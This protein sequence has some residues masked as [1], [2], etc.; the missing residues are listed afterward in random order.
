[1]H[2]EIDFE[3]F[4]TL[5]GRRKSEE[6]DYNDV[7]RRLLKLP[8]KLNSEGKSGD[9]EWVSKGFRFPEG[10]EFKAEFRG[11]EYFAAIRGGKFVYDG[12]AYNSF[13]GAAKVITGGQ[14]NGW[15]FWLQ[16]QPGGRWRK[17]Y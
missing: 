11:I 12:I 1:M 13:S 5:T 3:V 4:Q 17:V 14:R 8:P 16:K 2:V 6:D 9:S 15:D 7:I 10:T